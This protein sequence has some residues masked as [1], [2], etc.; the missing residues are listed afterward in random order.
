MNRSLNGTNGGTPARRAWL[1]RVHRWFGLAALLFVLFLSV[2]GIALNHTSAWHLDERYLGWS[3]LLDAYGI[4]APAPSA[5]F[6]AGDHRAT[7][8]GGR[9]YMDGRELARGIEVL[10]G[11]VATGDLVVVASEKDAFLLTA[12][13]ELVER[14]SLRETLPTTIAALGIANDRVVLRSGNAVFRFDEQLVTPEP[15]VADVPAGVRWST[16]TPPAPDQ[17]AAIEDLYR[18]RGVTVERLL[19]DLHSGRIL[20]RFGPLFMDAIAVL[21]ILLSLTG[22]LMWMQRGGFGNGNNS[23]R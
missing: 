5:S 13:G 4:E 23:G 7:L 15:W 18:G 20:T 8:V 2:T 6:A 22:L 21:L 11:M 19:K 10:A 16:S 9:L 3:W 17:L 1:R 14:M 12:K